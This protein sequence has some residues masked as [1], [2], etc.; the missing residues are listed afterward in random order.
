MS[1]GYRGRG[2]TQ[3]EVDAMTKKLTS[4]PLVVWWIRAWTPSTIS[5]SEGQVG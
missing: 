1:G 3:A 4:E 2:L 5:R